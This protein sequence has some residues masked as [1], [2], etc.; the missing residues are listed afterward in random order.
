[1]NGAGILQLLQPKVL[2]L[3]NLNRRIAVTPKSQISTSVL[4]KRL[5]H[6]SRKFDTFLVLRNNQGQQFLTK[7]WSSTEISIFQLWR[8]FGM[9]LRIDRPFQHET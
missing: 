7:N 6:C 4:F 8:H 2:T 1:M 5:P 9:S 3:E